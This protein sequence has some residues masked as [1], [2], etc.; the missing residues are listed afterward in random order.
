MSLQLPIPHYT[1]NNVEK[2]GV[3]GMVL[4][5]ENLDLRVGNDVKVKLMGETKFFPCIRD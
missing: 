1:F 2:V 5:W 4:V 3:V